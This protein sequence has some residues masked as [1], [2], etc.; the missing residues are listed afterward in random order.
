MAD[1]EQQVAGEALVNNGNGKKVQPYNVLIGLAAQ[2]ECKTHFAY[3][4]SN[5]IAYSGELV[6]AT[7][8]KFPL[9]RMA[10]VVIEGTLIAPQRQ[11]IALNA[12]A[13]GRTH[14]LWIDTDMRFPKNGL[15]RLLSHDK[16]I[17]AANYC[18]RRNRNTLKMTAAHDYDHAIKKRKTAWT[19]HDSTGLEEVKT[20][21]FGFCLTKIEVFQ[22]L[23][24]PYFAVP[25]IKG[26]GFTGEDVWFCERA[27]EAGFPTLIDHDLSKE[28]GHI[29]SW[30]FRYDHALT[31]REAELARGEEASPTEKDRKSTRLNSSHSDRSRMPSSA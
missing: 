13:Q 9:A 23:E 17:V 4:L 10:T 18:S 20:C 28:V 25:Y 16:P 3:D 30:E 31:Q 1:R 29:G 21:G 26:E 27:K 15:A 12:L 5:L 6:H 14:I 11:D 7:E 2:D 24:L 22:A 19:E 8:G